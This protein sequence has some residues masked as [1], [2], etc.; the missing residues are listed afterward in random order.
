MKTIL[1]LETHGLRAVGLFVLVAVL[2]LGA[3]GALAETAS[4][5]LLAIG[6]IHGDYEALVA[7]LQEAHIVDSEGNWVAGDTVL[8][9]TGDLLDRGPQVRKIMDLLMT[10]EAGA[11]EQGGRVVVLLGNHE[12]MNL[13]G[14]WRDVSAE[15]Y[16]GFV[17]E[18][19]EQRR[20]DSYQDYVALLKSRS[21]ILETSPVLSEESERQWMEVHPL[22]FFEYHEALGPQGHY[23]RWLRERPAIAQIA[24]SVFLHGGIHPELESLK[25]EEINR[26][27]GREIEAFDAYTEEMVR[28]RLILPFSSLQERVVAAQAELARLQ[29]KGPAGETQ[30][31]VQ[32]LEGFLGFGNWLSVHPD[33]PLWF[34]GFARWSEQEGR[35]HL[36]G[37]LESHKAK[38][39]V[40]GHTPL[41]PGQ[42]QARF[43]GSV[44][45]ID[46]GMLS[47]FYRGGSIEATE[48]NFT[49]EIGRHKEDEF[50]LFFSLPTQKRP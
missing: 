42:I 35:E 33:G 41:L 49:T 6:D 12:M 15:A 48:R 45:L 8:V 23:G 19:S 47:S 13:M 25:L 11:E 20:Q 3:P 38:R 29:P 39:F 16:L 2:A 10:L 28:R 18:D 5:R 7:I 31:V 50:S 43:E 14:D 1:E 46:T 26:R 4:S 21:S 30:N 34:R 27:I 9:Q 24:D 37:L 36:K 32:L 22:G 17:D 44:F 40:V